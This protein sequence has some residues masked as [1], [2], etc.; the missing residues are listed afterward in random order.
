MLNL[1]LQKLLAKL[2]YKF[3]VFINLN[4]ALCGW[5]DKKIEGVYL[6]VYLFLLQNEL[7]F[8]LFFF[9]V[10]AKKTAA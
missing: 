4:L 2:N 8:V 6:L 7:P 9:D 1:S 3:T 5:V 10:F